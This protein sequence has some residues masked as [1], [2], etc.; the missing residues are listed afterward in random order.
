MAE[1]CWRRAVEASAIDEDDLV[2]VNVDG[3]DIAV[4][5]LKGRFFATANICT[6]ELACLSDGYVIGDVIECPRHQ[7]QFHIPTGKAKGAPVHVN[8]R[9]YPVRVEEG[10]VYVDVGA[11]EGD[12]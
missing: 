12:A 5:N 7:G 11:G 1:P 3:H 6:H 9:T 8:L 4:Y 10:A 2:G